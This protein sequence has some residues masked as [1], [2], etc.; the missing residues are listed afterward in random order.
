[1]LAHGDYTRLQAAVQGGAGDAEVA[2]AARA[3]VARQEEGRRIGGLP[4]PFKQLRA[5]AER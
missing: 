4:V 2:A 5:P 1:M 3:Y